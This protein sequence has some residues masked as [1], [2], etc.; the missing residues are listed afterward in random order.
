MPSC[1][2]SRGQFLRRTAAIVCAGGC[3]LRVRLIVTP[4]VLGGQHFV[5]AVSLL[6]GVVP[7]EL[8]ACGQESNQTEMA[9]P[10]CHRKGTYPAG[11]PGPVAGHTGS[12]FGS[13]PSPSEPV[14]AWGRRPRAP[15]SPR[16]WEEGT[17]ASL[18]NPRIGAPVPMEGRLSLVSTTERAAESPD[19]NPESSAS[20]AAS[21]SVDYPGKIIYLEV[22]LH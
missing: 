1:C 14:A 18:T 10:H 22:F 20:R 2:N 16:R 13:R 6:S 5:W 8:L 9:A 11:S 3:V 19:R 7:G 15:G 21:C 12:G 4:L 17:S